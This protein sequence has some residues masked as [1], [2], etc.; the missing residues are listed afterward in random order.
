MKE[1][2]NMLVN[3]INGTDQKDTLYNIQEVAEFLHVHV[4]TLRRWSN[5]GKITSLRINKRGDRRFRYQD[6]ESFL[7]TFNPAKENTNNLSSE[8]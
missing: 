4:N 6:I 8:Q 2:L 1:Y 7:E 3:K 5:S